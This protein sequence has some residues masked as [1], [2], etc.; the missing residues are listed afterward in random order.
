MALVHELFD[1]PLY[2][3][4]KDVAQP[5][6]HYSLIIIFVVHCIDSM[7]CVTRK[8]VFGGFRPGLTQIWLYSHRRCLET[9]NF[10][11]RKQKNS[12]VY[13]AKTKALITCT[14]TTQLICVF[15]FAYAKSRF[16]HDAV[17]IISLVSKKTFQESSS[18]LWL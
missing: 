14:V 6:Q 18:P 11:S 10:K 1:T 9:S 8:L 2:M 15:V 12:T 3:G 17:C 4:D 13:V 7:S 16:S 5:V